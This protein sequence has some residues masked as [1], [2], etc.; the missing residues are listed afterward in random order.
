MPR[1]VGKQSQPDKTHNDPADKGRP[2]EAVQED[3]FSYSLPHT[4][5]SNGLQLGARVLDNP[6]P[7]V[8]F[9]EAGIEFDT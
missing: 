3:G 4:K 7:G 6:V 1:F 2:R 8:I 5:V 9:V